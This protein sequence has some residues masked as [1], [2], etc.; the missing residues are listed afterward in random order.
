MTYYSLLNT[1]KKLTQKHY[2]LNEFGEG[3]VYEFMNSGNHKYP[4]LFITL[5]NISVDEDSTQYNFTLFYIDRLTDDLNNKI[6][7]QT[8]GVE[9]VKQILA[10]LVD[11]IGT[12]TVNSVDYT[13]FTEKFADMCGGVFCNVVLDDYTNN[14]ENDINNN[15]DDSDFSVTEIKLTKNGIYDVA[16]YD[17]AI[18][19]I[20]LETLIVEESGEYINENGGWDKVV[21]ENVAKI[22]EDSV[23]VMITDITNEVIEVVPEE[24]FDGLKRVMIYNDTADKKTST[25]INIT[26][27]QSYQVLGPS[28]G[29]VWNKVVVDVNCPTPIPITV[30]ANGTYSR[31][32]GYNP[33]IVNTPRYEII[34][35]N[36]KQYNELTEYNGYAIYLIT[37]D[38]TKPSEIGDYFY[39]ESQ[40]DDNEIIF[41]ANQ[42]FMDEMS[43]IAAEETA[44]YFEFSTDRY[45]WYS[46]KDVV[47]ELNP[48]RYSITLNKYERLFIRNTKG[49]AIS[50]FKNSTDNPF[51]KI[52]STASKKFNIGGDLHT[53]IFKYTDRI[54]ELP[55]E[56]NYLRYIFGFTQNLVD[57]GDLLLPATKLYY[58]A[59]AEMFEYCRDLI[60]APKVLPADDLPENVYAQMFKG[61]NALVNP[62]ELPAT[63]LGLGCYYEMFGSC[64]SLVNAPELLA[65]DLPKKTAISYGVYNAMFINCTSL[66]YV[67]C[68]GL[69]NIA[70][71][72]GSMLYN[73][74]NGSGKLVKHPDAEWS[75][76]PWGVPEGWTIENAII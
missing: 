62:P 6:N 67:K 63:T 1:L 21:V 53:L 68:L 51:P 16:G 39:I 72:K 56:L 64:T 19:S 12:L 66:R 36:Q 73:I 54:T 22:Q 38:N 31:E 69:T 45:E 57:A 9:I 13:M 14:L 5:S 74:N 46:L 42:D 3:D 28:D 33:V 75:I 11:E 7:V 44:S 18:V 70:D 40:E 65:I 37:Y 24:G 29:Y 17:K 26:N 52:V 59:Y 47:T 4:C 58:G 35:L 23:E 41:C 55:N 50:Y 2:L 10:R 61:C 25:T 71:N 49:D 34:S 48:L 43:V 27:P 30:I 60:S 20:P 76:G 15:C 8:T 32:G